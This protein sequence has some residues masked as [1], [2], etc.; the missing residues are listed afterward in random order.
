MPPVLGPVSPSPTRLKSCAGASGTTVV[1]V[2]EAEQRDLGAVEVL[3][4][5]DLRRRPAR[6]RRACASGLGAV[7]GDDDALAGGQPVVLDDVRRAE[8]VQRVGH[9]GGG[10]ADVR[11]RGGHPGRGHHLLGEG[12]AA[13]ELRRLRGRAEAGDARARARRRRRRPPAGP[14]GRRRPGR[15]PPRRPGR[16]RRRRRAGST[17]RSRQSA[18]RVDAGVAGG[19]DD[20]VD[21][22]VGGQGGARWR[23]RG[24][25]IRGRGPSR[26][27]TVG[28]RDREAQRPGGWRHRRARG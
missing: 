8:R 28:D 27:T 16:R 7:V 6:Q 23:A 2:G 20:G 9:L 3:L 26:A 24:H 4:D 19:G 13:L 15:R 22:R 18:M 21:R 17:G 10:R 11:Q 12:L 14:R 25:R 5:H 1:A